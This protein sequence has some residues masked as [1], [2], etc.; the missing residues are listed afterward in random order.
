MISGGSFPD[1]KLLWPIRQAHYNSLTSVYGPKSAGDLAYNIIVSLYILLSALIGWLAGWLVNYLADVLPATRRLSS[2]ACPQCRT[3]YPLQRYLA[4]Q[5]C[6]QCGRARTPRAWIVQL[7]LTTAGIYVWTHQPRM[8][9]GLGFVLLAYF[10]LVFVIDLE[11]RLILHPTSLF[12]AALG[13]IA[14]YRAHG[15]ADTLLGGLGGTAIMLG[16]YLLGTLVSRWRAGRMRRAGHLPDDEEA[17]GAG[18]VILAGILGL[19][20]GW[21]LI[22]FSLL[23]GVLLGGLIGMVVVAAMLLSRRYKNNAM[24][25]FMPYGP[26]LIVSAAF[27]LFLPNW[28]SAVVPK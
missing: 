13:L 16:L 17:L 21:P 27:I 26:C 25:V 23:L 12:G 15:L 28:I 22:W 3:I 18:D 2:P 9:F 7:F 14:G 11:H 8:G 24:M 10:A 6:T 1:C 20:L 19:V 5:A 4:M